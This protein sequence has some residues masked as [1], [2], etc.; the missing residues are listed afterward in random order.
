MP[1]WTWR[2]CGYV[3]RVQLWVALGK[4]VSDLEWMKG[5][6]GVEVNYLFIVFIVMLLSC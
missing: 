2:R 6:E 5:I 3:E 1:K 4:K